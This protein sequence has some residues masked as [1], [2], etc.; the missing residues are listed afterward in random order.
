[1]TFFLCF[2]AFHKLHIQP[3]RETIINGLNSLDKIKFTS[4]S[5][6]KPRRSQIPRVVTQDKKNYDSISSIA[7]VEDQKLANG[8]S[9]EVVRKKVNFSTVHK[10]TRRLSNQQLLNQ[11]STSFPRNV[12]VEANRKENFHRNNSE[13]NVKPEK[14]IKMSQDVG[15]CCA[16][17]ILCLFNFIFFVSIKD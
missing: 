10:P 4:E 7:L 2:Q 11:N 15:S 8:S 5:S 12:E 3:Q 16:K 9:L 1:M 17:Y 13:N 6:P 14:D